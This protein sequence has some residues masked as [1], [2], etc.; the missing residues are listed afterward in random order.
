MPTLLRHVVEKVPSIG[1]SLTCRLQHTQNI[2]V[3]Y[4]DY[5]L[6]YNDRLKPSTLLTVLGITCLFFTT[7]YST[8]VLVIGMC[9]S[10]V[11]ACGRVPYTAGFGI[12]YR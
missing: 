2:M 5:D 7:A 11:S 9:I 3:F 10:N 6:Q 8:S 1:V 4:W 12:P